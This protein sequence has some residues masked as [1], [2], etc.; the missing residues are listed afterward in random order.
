VW[1]GVFVLVTVHKKRVLG[2][3]IRQRNVSTGAVKVSNY[4][5]HLPQKM[6]K[7]WKKSKKKIFKII[8][9]DIRAS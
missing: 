8:M 9:K 4:I 3:K 1:G 6:R 7:G 2:V 5:N